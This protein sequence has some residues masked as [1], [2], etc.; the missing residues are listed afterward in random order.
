M[1]HLQEKSE[2]KGQNRGIQRAPS[3]GSTSSSEM[4]IRE[5]KKGV[6]L[7]S[8]GLMSLAANAALRSKQVVSYE[9]CDEERSPEDTS[10]P[11]S[12]PNKAVTPSPYGAS[13]SRST[14]THFGPMMTIYGNK[15][16]LTS[17][18][19]SKKRS[20]DSENEVRKSP[21]PTMAQPEHLR[22]RIGSPTD[23]DSVKKNLNEEL[24]KKRVLDQAEFDD[25]VKRA[26]SSET[27]E[28]VNA[29]KARTESPVPSSFPKKKPIISPTSSGEKG[30]DDESTGTAPRAGRFPYGRAF[31]HPG[32][33]PPPPPFGHP[34]H[35]YV[36]PYAHAYPAFGAAYPPQPGFMAGR[37]HHPAFYPPYPPPGHSFRPPLAG[38]PPM[39]GL[40]HLGK[41]VK[42]P[43]TP[44][45]K[46]RA[47]PRPDSR[48][49]I[50]W[51]LATAQGP[52][53]STNRCIPLKAPILSRY[54]RYV[55]RSLYFSFLVY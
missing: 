52:V 21:S 24:S 5:A 22:Y 50:D 12:R 42:G 43:V 3:D 8:E 44:A 26:R 28:S 31:G 53:P 49:P 36:H 19:R 40:H 6:L 33:A 51:Q 2:S 10:T 46:L 29:G 37:P 25:V 55:F 41:E 34:A 23:K 48:S 27:S 47:S 14:P 35:P 11:L 7:G 30:E 18:I 54:W 1:P 9:S 39:A 32:Y 17:P 15:R 13:A 45:E 20:T 4:P 38:S 16:L